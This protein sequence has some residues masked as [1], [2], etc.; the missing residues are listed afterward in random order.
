MKKVNVLLVCMLLAL[1]AAAQTRNTVNASVKLVQGKTDFSINEPI[2][3]RSIQ[4]RIGFF[5][6]DNFSIGLCMENG[7]DLDQ[8]LPFGLTF[9]GRYYTGNREHHT[10]RFFVEAG[11]G[12]GHLILPT[13]IIG[14]ELEGNK[15][16]SAMAYISPGVN[17]F[18][19]KVWSL[20][21][22]PEYRYIG[23]V[24]PAHRLG[25]SAG[26]SL[27]LCESTF[28]KIFSHEFTKLY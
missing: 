22:A 4:S 9:Y 2:N 21:L 23:G 3:E 6:T 14:N 18:V 7:L 1:T 25:V 19:G 15:K 8:T 26:L 13:N 11:G 5:P 28:K 20:E 24:Q 10:V 27:F 17:V 16:F 12:A